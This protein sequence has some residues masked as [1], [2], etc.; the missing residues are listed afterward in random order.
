[1]SRLLTALVGLSLCAFAQPS[2]LSIYLP[3]ATSQP[4]DV[5]QSAQAELSRVLE[6]LEMQ[7]N[8]R[9]MPEEGGEAALLVVARFAGS[10]SFADYNPAKA[11][12]ANAG[13][14]LASTA[15]TDGK[16]LPFVTLECNRVRDRI[17]PLAVGWKAGERNAA[18]GRAVGRVLAHEIY[19]VLTGDLKHA[20]EG[21]A[22]SC[23][24]ARELL[25]DRFDLDEQSIAQMRPPRPE[26]IVVADGFE[27]EATGR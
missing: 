2:A 10:C 1:M 9:N 5:V 14:P 12:N 4:A 13:L 26:P 25:A 24:S 3:N 16:V 19:H 8:W 11:I 27:T 20:R 17:A 15:V 21:V 18:L 23:V 7:I 6:R 22:A